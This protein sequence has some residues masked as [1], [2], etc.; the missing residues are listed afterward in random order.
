VTIIVPADGAIL[1]RILESTY[2]LW[3][4]GLT[5]QAYRQ[6]DAAQMKTGWASG[7]LRRYAL[8]DGPDLLASAKQYNLTAIVDRRP[9]RVCGIGAIF[10][11]PDRRGCG[12]EGEL[13]ERLIDRAAGAGAEMAL[14][15][16]DV[17]YRRDR[18]DGFTIVATSEVE[19]RVQESPRHGAPMTLVRGGEARDLAAIVAMGQ[20]RAAPFRFHLDRDVSLAQH[21]ITR[22]RLLAGLGTPRARELHFFIAEEGITAAAYIVISVIGR[23]WTIEECGDRDATGARVGALLQALV[24]R[25]PSERR[26]SVKGWLPYGFV[27]PQA[28]IVSAGPSTQSMMVRFLGARPAPAPLSG[29][30]V[31]Y[32][33]AD[34]F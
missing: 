8:V 34:R 33:R 14:L 26:P 13:I 6:F 24:A 10:T 29:D 32:W 4:D 31:L 27:P 11:E 22:K 7:H 17:A 28:T 23:E 21:A 1:D 2:P 16:S 12:H 15:F 25:E 20:I 3:H 9:L 19:L 18:L 30:E 5:R